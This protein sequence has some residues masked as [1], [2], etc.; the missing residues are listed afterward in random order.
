LEKLDIQAQMASLVQ[1]STSVLGSSIEQNGR[2]LLM[3]EDNTHQYDLGGLQRESGKVM[4]GGG[5]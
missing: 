2:L 4:L 1:H 3:E 5:W